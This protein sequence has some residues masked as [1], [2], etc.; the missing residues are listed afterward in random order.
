[1]IKGY[2]FIKILEFILFVFFNMM[3]VING[4]W[5][6]LTILGALYS[7]IWWTSSNTHFYNMSVKLFASAS[8]TFQKW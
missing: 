1:M 3:H 2:N 4:L 7:I 6:L 8:L 5:H